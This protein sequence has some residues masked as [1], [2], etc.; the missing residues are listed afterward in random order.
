VLGVA[1]AEEP[2]TGGGRGIE[3][4]DA[5]V[6]KKPPPL[7]EIFSAG[8]PKGDTGISDAELDAPRPPEVDGAIGKDVAVLGRAAPERAYDGGVMAG[9][10]AV[11]TAAE[12]EA[13]KSTAAD[14]GE[15]AVCGG[16][17]ESRRR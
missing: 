9:G 11:A 8:K 10:A 16:G 12:D 6:W 7:E 4:D 13:A 3:E 2:E 5:V 14:R 1:D 17:G 15:G